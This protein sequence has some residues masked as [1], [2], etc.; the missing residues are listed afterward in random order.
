MVVHIKFSTDPAVGYMEIW[1]DGAK[2]TFLDG[3]QK[4][5]YQTFDPDATA[6]GNLQLTN[7]R[8][9]GMIPSAVTL[10][11]DE[12]KVGESYDAVAP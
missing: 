12:I 2:Q 4:R 11:Q 1:K 9:K 6:C 10:Y 3:T 7:Y 8:M 5:F